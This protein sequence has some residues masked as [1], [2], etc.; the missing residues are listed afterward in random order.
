MTEEAA[1]D[2]LPQIIRDELNY[3]LMV[4]SAYWCVKQLHKGRSA[5]AIVAQLRASSD[6]EARKPWCDLNGRRIESPYAYLFDSAANFQ[7]D[8]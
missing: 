8:I 5:E 4:W 3:G 7:L 2:I 1:F 6:K